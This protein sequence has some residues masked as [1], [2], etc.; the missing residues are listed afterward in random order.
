MKQ[1]SADVQNIGCLFLAFFVLLLFIAALI[2][3][4]S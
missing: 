4:H 3:K 1:Q 2:E